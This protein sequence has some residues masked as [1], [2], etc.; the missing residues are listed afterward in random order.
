MVRP[1]MFAGAGRVATISLPAPIKNVLNIEKG[2]EVELVF[3][4]R[5]KSKCTMFFKKK[6]EQP[7]E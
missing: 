7:K 4:L 1:I 5:D 6:A 3:D 2:D